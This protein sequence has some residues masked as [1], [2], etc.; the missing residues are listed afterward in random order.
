M[1]DLFNIKLMNVQVVGHSQIPWSFGS[2]G[3]VHVE[4]FKKGGAKLYDVETHDDLCYSLDNVVDLTILWIGGNDLF[5]ETGVYVSKEI[6]RLK[7][8]YLQNSQRVRV[9]AIESR[10]YSQSYNLE[11]Q[12]NAD[13]WNRRKN[14]VNHRLSL[15]ANTQGNYRVINFTQAQFQYNAY[16]GVHFPPQQVDYIIDRFET[17]IGHVKNE[18]AEAEYMDM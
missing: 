12:E 14:K 15:Y 4:L 3:D 5:D 6:L 11:W 9:C 2:Y 13:L 7:E 17:V 16:D 10:D 1:A 18:L 8:L